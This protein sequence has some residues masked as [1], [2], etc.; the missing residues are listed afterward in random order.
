MRRQQS[1]RCVQTVPGAGSFSANMAVSVPRVSFHR[2]FVVVP[3]HHT[4]CAVGHDDGQFFGEPR[5]E[6]G[7]I[8]IWKEGDSRG[9]VEIVHQSWRRDVKQRFGFV[10]AGVA[11]LECGGRMTG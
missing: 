3:R 4:G 6:M 9:R 1:C 5:V 8:P 10:G 2:V 11:A 7:G